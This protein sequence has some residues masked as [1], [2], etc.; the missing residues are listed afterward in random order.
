MQMVLYL[1][2]F[3]FHYMVERKNTAEDL[4]PR[5]MK[6]VLLQNLKLTDQR[7]LFC[8]A[9]CRIDNADDCKNCNH[10]AYKTDNAYYEIQSPRNR[11]DD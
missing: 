9:C 5:R 1:L 7:K 2:P 6:Y 8:F 3:A 4:T 11:K 10:N